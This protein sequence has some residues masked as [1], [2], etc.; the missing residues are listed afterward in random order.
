MVK[1]R[2]RYGR[3]DWTRDGLKRDKAHQ[4]KRIFNALPRHLQP[5]TSPTNPRG[6][7]GAFHA[8]EERVRVR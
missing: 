7:K 4:W 2:G 1:R 8:H 6:D 5:V 3:G